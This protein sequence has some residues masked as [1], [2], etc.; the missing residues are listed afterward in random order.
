MFALSF[1]SLEIL[2]NFIIFTWNKYMLVENFIVYFTCLFTFVWLNAKVDKYISCGNVQW[3]VDYKNETKS[4]DT[5]TQVREGESVF[6]R[7]R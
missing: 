3:I 7:H 4:R 6:K 2:M 1:D 5:E